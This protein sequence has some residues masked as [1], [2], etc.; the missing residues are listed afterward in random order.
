[1][2]YDLVIKSGINITTIINKLKTKNFYYDPLNAEVLICVGGD[3]TVLGAVRE[4]L[5]KNKNLPII[6]INLGTVGFLT[7]FNSV[8]HFLETNQFEINKA[9]LIKLTITN[10][11]IY[12][13]INEV[14]IRNLS[15]TLVLKVKIGQEKLEVIRGGGICI[16]TQLGSTALNKSLGG[17]I[18]FPG[19]LAYQIKQVAPITNVK[20]P[21]IESPL[22]I[23]NNFKT[24]IKTEGKTELLVSIDNYYLK[25]LD[26][27]KAIVE[28]CENVI[29]FITPKANSYV[30][31]LERAF[32]RS[33]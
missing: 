12:Y 26:Y 27:E 9:N 24:V 2:K 28:I 22:I 3:G 23:P 4:M 11:K 8:E 14:T 21:N 33:E 16:S 29:S 1:M 6:T 15:E 20:Y 30:K 19:V 7:N 31:K 32:I 13:A 18:L 10:D 5:L 17:A 25:I